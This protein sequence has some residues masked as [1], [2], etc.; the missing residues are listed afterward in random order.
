MKNLFIVLL[1]ILSLNVTANELQWVDEQIQ[2]IKPPR[3]GVLASKIDATKNPFIGIKEQISTKKK[4]KRRTSTKKRTSSSTKTANKITKVSHLFSLDAIINKTALIN[5]KWYKLNSKVG[6][7][8]L[9]EINKTTV[10]LSYKGKKLLLSTQ[11]KNKTLKF[12]NN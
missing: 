6:K 9:N 1:F 8:T 5:G 3:V 2:A 12:R 11:T 10:F 4:Q 7:Y